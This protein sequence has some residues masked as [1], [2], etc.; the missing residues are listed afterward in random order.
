[1]L[2]ARLVELREL[3]AQLPAEIQS[4]TNGPYLVTNVENLTNW[5]GER[6]ATRPQMAL[7]R[8]GRSQLKPF[9]AGTH[10]EIGFV[11]EKDLKRVPDR[12]DTYVGQQ[13]TV[14]DN[15]GICQHSG[16]CTDRLATAFTWAR[17]RS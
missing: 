16:F 14:M 10:A 8:C 13:V 12:R 4:Q 1:M 3:E 9:C 2:A 7:C 17:S 6:L 5:L 11:A 15:R